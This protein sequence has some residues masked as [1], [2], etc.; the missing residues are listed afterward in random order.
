M[1]GARGGRRVGCPA[2]RTTSSRR[3]KRRSRRSGREVQNQLQRRNDLIPN[4]VETVKGY[5]AHEEGVFKDIADARVE[6]ARGASRRRRRSRPRTSRPRARP[7]ARGRRELPEPQGERTVQP[8][9]GRARRH[10]EP[11]RAARGALQRARS[12]NTTRQRRKFPGNVT[13]K[14]FGFKDIPTSKRRPRRRRRR[15]STSR[16]SGVAGHLCDETSERL[17]YSAR[18][19]WRCALGALGVCDGDAGAALS[20]RARR[21]PPRCRRQSTQRPIRSSRTSPGARSAPPTWAA[22]STTSRSSRATPRHSTSASRPAASGKPS[23]TAR[24]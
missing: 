15:R 4:L 19:S 3:R 20:R 18:D 2:V 6:A 8:P 7:A 11:A 9:D 21:R 1:R 23:T 10:R 13:A 14:M 5:A 24:R 16:S 12:R 17:E 22:A